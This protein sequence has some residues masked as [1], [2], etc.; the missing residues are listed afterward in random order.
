[1]FAVTGN[2]PEQNNHANSDS[3]EI[4]RI[5]DLGTAHTDA[6]NMF[7]PSEWANPKNSDDKDFGSSSP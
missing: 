6:M 3:E 7:Y 4:L 2:A 1:M 5:T